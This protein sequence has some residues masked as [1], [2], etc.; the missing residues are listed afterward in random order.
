MTIDLNG[1]CERCF[2]LNA[3]KLYLLRLNNS[4]LLMPEIIN[5]ELESATYLDINGWD[6]TFSPVKE[7]YFNTADNATIRIENFRF[8]LNS[9]FT[10]K[11]SKITNNTSFYGCTFNSF[12]GDLSN[13][14][15]DF[16]GFDSAKMSDNA[17]DDVL[18]HLTTFPSSDYQSR[19]IYFGCLEEEPTLTEESFTK[20]MNKGW[21]V[22]YNGITYETWLEQNAPKS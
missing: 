7:F 18:S 6:D 17:I 1:T 3:P 11:N 22:V 12:D 4:A 13:I 14:T 10:L 8:D 21:N 19:T 16:Y 2:K 15:T 5:L 20:F 9:Q